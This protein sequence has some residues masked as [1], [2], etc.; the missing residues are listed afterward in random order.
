MALKSGRCPAIWVAWLASLLCSLA[1]AAVLADTPPDTALRVTALTAEVREELEIT[2]FYRKTVDADGVAVIGSG[3][4]SDY[5]LLECAWVVDHMLAGCDRIKAALA[6]G[7]VRVGVIAVSEFTMDLPENQQPW[8][9]AR[10][11]FHDRRSRGLGGDRYATCG[12]EN[13][14]G[15]RGD[16]YSAENIL[17]HEFAHTIA[18]NLRRVDAEW[19]QQLENLYAQAMAEGLW[20]DTYAATNVQEYWAEAT[21]SWFDCNN[22]RADGRVHNGIWNREKL[23][24]YD[25]RLA[26]FLAATFGENSWRYTKIAERSSGQCGHL[27]GFDRDQ[28]P[29]FRFEN[30]PRIRTKSTR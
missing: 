14:L 5:A 25:P 15:L 4:V 19:W 10:A 23:A 3:E 26:R 11:A 20:S 6:A 21:Q 24:E 27:Q 2:E 17:I 8:M 7:K 29:T 18:S 28:M 30:S 1:C 16:P 13:L 12:E 22:P 9:Q